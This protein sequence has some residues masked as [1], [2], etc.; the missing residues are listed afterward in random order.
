[1]STRRRRKLLTLLGSA[2]LLTMMISTASEED[3]INKGGYVVVGGMNGF[4]QFQNT[5]PLVTNVENTMGFMIQGGYR[6]NRIFAV[7]AEGDFYSGFDSY[8]LTGLVDPSLPAVSKLTVDGGNVTVNALAYLP[9][10]RFQPFALVGVGGMWAR[11]RSTNAVNLACGPAFAPPA[12]GFCRGAYASLGN[13][14]G[15]VMKFG[16]G[17]DVYATEDWA[18]T[19]NTAYVL[20]FGNVEDFRYVHLGWGVRFNF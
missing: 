6:A 14:G 3:F 8:V 5:A 11:L 20:P 19:V 18:L 12:F 7:E 13:T 4:Q 2:L 9:F 17:F 15:F 16:G 10:G 1:M